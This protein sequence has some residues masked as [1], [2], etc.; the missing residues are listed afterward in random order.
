[1]AFESDETRYEFR[2]F[3][4]DLTAV[5]DAFAKIG[6]GEPH[7]ASRETYI[8]TRLNID[9]NV[10]IRGGRLQVKTLQARSGELEQWARPLNAEFPVAVT[11]I[12]SI[13]LPALGLDIEI[14][15]GGAFGEGALLTLARAQHALAVAE[16]EK[17]RTLFD[18]DVCVAEFCL[19]QIGEEKLQTIAVEAVDPLAAL[20]LLRGIGLTEAQNESYAAFLQRRL[21]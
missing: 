16:V 13:V 4:T 20:T 6:K 18:L 11:D 2:Q 7:A 3:G 19:L 5:R 12:E 8:V 14:G 17:Q 21:F 10:K 1:M 9:S 15:E